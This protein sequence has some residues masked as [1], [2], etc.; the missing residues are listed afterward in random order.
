M[1]KLIFC[2][3]G[4]GGEFTREEGGRRKG[5][6]AESQGADRGPNTHGYSLVLV[7]Q[8]G[9]AGVKGLGRGWEGPRKGV[10]SRRAVSGHPESKGERKIQS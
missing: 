2:R 1:K 4:K 8:S 6:H 10:M 7:E 3:G 9:E 5:F